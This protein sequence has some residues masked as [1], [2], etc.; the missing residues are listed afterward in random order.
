MEARK[1]ELQILAF[2]LLLAAWQPAPENSASGT[3]TLNGAPIA[4]RYAYATAKP[5][6]FDK[7]SE[8]VH[9]LLS[10]VPLPGDAREDPFGLIRLA[11]E[12][13]AAIVEVVI[14]ARGNP[15]S[16]AIYARPFNGMAS[17]SGIHRFEKETFD[18]RMASGRLSMDG[19]REFADVEFHYEAR[20]S[21]AIPRPPTKEELAALL[22]SPAAA[23][24]RDYLAAVRKGDLESFVSTLSTPR[25]S[26]FAGH[27]GAARF[28]ALR[29]EMPLNL[30]L[31]GAK[32]SPD[33]GVLVSAEAEQGG[34]VIEYVLKMVEEGGH[35][36][37]GK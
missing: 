33:G 10:S 36:K 23:A 9:V 37:V 12:G 3:L 35:W 20:F 11:R 7:Q 14:D 4:L 21:A 1:G 29:K 22:E 2:L 31:V 28:E 25:R 15:I 27:K 34:V 19:P 13:K 16:G 32:P 18:G 8:D 26:E 6:F 24:A 30:R 17:L 5:G